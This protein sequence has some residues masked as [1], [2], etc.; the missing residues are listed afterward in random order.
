MA[1]TAQGLKS[2][3]H[4]HR[5]I[6][7]GF[8]VICLVLLLFVLGEVTMPKPQ[9]VEIGQAQAGSV[10]E[11]KTGDQLQLSLEGNPTTGYSWE[12]AELDPNILKLN[13]EPQFQADSSALGSGGKMVLRFETVNPGRTPLKLI[14][15]RP[16]EQN[17]APLRTYEVIVVLTK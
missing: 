12:V 1:I 13:G 7:V 16:F 9:T 2:H 11:L 8:S 14:Y 15:H 4:L 10:I 3:P 6:W 17:T 5:W